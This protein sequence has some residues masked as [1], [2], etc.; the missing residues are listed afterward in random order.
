MRRLLRIPPAPA[1]TANVQLDTLSQVYDVG[2]GGWANPDSYVYSA[3]PQTINGAVASFCVNDATYG[4]PVAV[5]QSMGTRPGVNG[6]IR[7]PHCY[8][9]V[10]GGTVSPVTFG[11]QLQ[12]PAPFGFTI[13]ATT[14]VNPGNY[15][16][17]IPLNCPPDMRLVFT[18]GAGGAGDTAS[19]V[20]MTFQSQ[21]DE[22]PV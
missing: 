6:F 17:P 14:I 3:G 11:I 12:D 2:Q 20:G 7:Q 8:V 9:S 15:Y 4:T 18:V 21:G 22:L 1:P 10:A 5:A 19:F 16:V 13:V